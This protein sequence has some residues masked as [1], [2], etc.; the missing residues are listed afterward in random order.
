M[1]S[2]TLDAEALYREV[3]RAMQQ[4]LASCDRSPRLVGVASGGVWLAERL[5][6]DLAL[7]EEIGTLSSAMHRDDFSQRGLSAGG[8]T[9]LPFDVNGADLIVLD[10][11]PLANI[12][13]SNSVSMVMVNGRLFEGNTLDELYPRKKALVRQPW[14]YTVPSAAAGTRR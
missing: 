13:N 9:V 10:R 7:A 11:D 6:T 4:I 1:S 14:S 12:R 3:L 5:R 2:L 8:Q